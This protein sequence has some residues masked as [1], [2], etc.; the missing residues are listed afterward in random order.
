MQVTTPPSLP[1]VLWRETIAPELGLPVSV[2]FAKKSQGIST[3]VHFVHSGEG[4]FVLRFYPA[5]AASRM[6]GY[7]DAHDYLL[8]LG[9]RVAEP[10][11]QGNGPE[12]CTWIVERRAA[13]PDIKESIRNPQFLKRA[14]QT[15]ARLHSNQRPRYGDIGQ[16]GGKRLSLRWRQRFPERWRKVT[17]LFP[18]LIPITSTVETWFIDWTDRFA[19]SQYQLLHGDYHPGNLALDENGEI[20]LLDLRSP[21]YGFG[22]AELIESAHHFTGEEPSDWKPFS[23]AYVESIDASSKALFSQHQGDLHAVFHL[24]HADRFAGLA[25]GTRGDVDDHRR[26]ER[27]AFDN[28]LR[29]ATIA[30]IESPPIA[31]E[32]ESPFPS[33]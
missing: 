26:W 10:V 33:L 2:E 22:L 5:S 23:S 12:G 4:D 16:V 30:G 32:R 19:P 8:K 6:R 1:Q 7:R 15:L 18:E 9:L 13:G 21:R 20:V 25:V 11:G 31:C 28:W 3:D 14:A 29:F 17:A 27:N 24:R